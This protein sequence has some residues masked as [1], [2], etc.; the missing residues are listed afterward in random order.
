MTT[1]LD[2]AVAYRTSPTQYRGRLSPRMRAM[3]GYVERN[4][5]AI[6]VIALGLDCGPWSVETE[7]ALTRRGLLART[8]DKWDVQLTE[9]GWLWLQANPDT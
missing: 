9:A 2:P 8:E 7:K 1:D 3:L 5:C 4:G 6:G